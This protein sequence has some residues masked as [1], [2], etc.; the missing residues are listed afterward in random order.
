MMSLP[1]RRGLWTQRDTGMDS[2]RKALSVSQG[3]KAQE[4]PNL[5]TP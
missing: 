3:K 2:Q 5:P 4:K 1:V